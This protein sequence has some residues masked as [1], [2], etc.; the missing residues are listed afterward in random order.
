MEAGPGFQ[1]QK[2]KKMPDKF[3]LKSNFLEQYFESH[4]LE[5]NVATDMGGNET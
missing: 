5:A 3:V 2:I 4:Y 1:N